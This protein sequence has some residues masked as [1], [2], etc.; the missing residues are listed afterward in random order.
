MSGQRK[1][2]VCVA[3]GGLLFVN[4]LM[5][6]PVRYWDFEGDPRFW[7]GN[8]QGQLTRVPGVVGQ[9]LVFDGH[10]TEVADARV[11]GAPE[12]LTLSAWVAPQEYSWNLSAIVDQQQDLRKGYMLGINHRGQLVGG[13]G[14]KDRWVQ[15]TSEK[16]LPLLK[17]SHIAMTFEAGKGLRMFIN[18]ELVRSDAI[19]ADPVFAD[20]TP[21]VLGRTQTRMSPSET[22]REPSRAVLSWMYFDGLMDEVR[23]E[24]VAL[25]DEEV[26][27][28]FAAVQPDVAQP[29]A[30]R[31]LPSGTDEPR[32][33]GAYLTRLRYS[34]GWDARWL[35][36][37]LPD[38]VVR[39]DN[40]PIKLILWRGTG[41]IPAMVTENDIWMAN[42]SGEHYGQDQ[43]WEAMGDKFSRY[44][45]VRLIE[46]HDARV[47]IH[48]RYALASISHKINNESDTQPGDWMDEYLTVWPDGVMVRKQVLW[49]ASFRGFYQFHETIF[50]NQPGTRPQDNVEYEAITFMDMSGKTASYC[51]ENGIPK[52]FPEPAHKPVEMVN[53]KSRYRPFSIHPPDRGTRHFRFGATRGYSTFPCWNHWPVS[54]IPNDGRRAVA[55]DKPSH[56]SL[57][58]T[59]R[60]QQ[61]LERY[62]D[63]SIRVRSIWGMTTEGIESLLP[64]AKSWNFA[65]AV[66]SVS[67]GFAFENYEAYERAYIFRQVGSEADTATLAFEIHASEN[68]PL[69]NIPLVIRRWGRAGA[70]VRMDG[71]PLQV[72]TDFRVGH[73]ITLDSEDLVLWIACKTSKPLALQISRPM[74]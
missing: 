15:L 42:Q 28:R 22:E 7:P 57:A 55:P 35:G 18:G 24:H 3:V 41:Y 31:R 16:A 12:A 68:S 8:T 20:D 23:I 25:T 4:G 32:P 26:A 66:D 54:L 48:W 34:P 46:N 9:A 5:A 72:G 43:C 38:I 14:T 70:D 63:G 45:H 37:D 33:F 73:R 60:N 52:G 59:V 67:A 29:L 50:F 71:E 6:S 44:S 49:S 13:L 1:Q 53:T 69:V 56:S 61:P 2:M 27:E 39:F 10:R 65:P 36:S 30:F 21:V 11:G 47:Q 40:S 51:W 19:R 17:W 64:L 58:E 62:D 74:P